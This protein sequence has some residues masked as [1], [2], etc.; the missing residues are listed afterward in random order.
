MKSENLKEMGDGQ[1]RRE[2][3]GPY[4]LK[5][6]SLMAQMVEFA[7]NAED[8]SSIPGL[9]R[10]PGE[11]NGNPLQHPGLENSKDREA[12]QATV[13]GCESWTTK[14]AE[15]RKIDAFELWCWRSLL[16]IPWT[17]RR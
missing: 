5:R 10:S 9:G 17:A 13:R 2:V 6:A 12:M 4:K 11:R 16:R 7:C 1:R 14:K 15:H 3:F 8:L